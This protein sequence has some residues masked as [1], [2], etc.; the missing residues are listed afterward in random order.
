MDVIVRVQQ[1]CRCRESVWLPS[2]MLITEQTV[3]APGYDGQLLHAAA[4]V[5]HRSDD[6]TTIY[7]TIDKF[8][9]KIKTVEAHISEIGYPGVEIFLFERS[10]LGFLIRKR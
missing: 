1:G 2:N 8:H 9:R 5:R 7:N 6:Q 10:F 4:K 3:R